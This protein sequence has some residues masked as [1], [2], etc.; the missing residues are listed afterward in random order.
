MVMQERWLWAPYS[1]ISFE[2]GQ[3][4][5]AG[6]MTDISNEYLSSSETLPFHVTS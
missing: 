2:H 3:R 6:T 5:V 1:E 4:L